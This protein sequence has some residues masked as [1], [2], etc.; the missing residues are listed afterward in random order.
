MRSEERRLLPLAMHHTAARILQ[1]KIVITIVVVRVKQLRGK[2]KTN[3]SR[4]E[5]VELSPHHRTNVKTE[6]GS[7]K[8]KPL[9]LESIVKHHIEAA[10]HGNDQLLQT[11]V[12]VRTPIG[13]TGNVIRVIDSLNVERDMMV[14]L[15]K[16]QISPGIRNFR[17]V[18]QAAG[19]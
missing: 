13:T 15:N 14:A 19:V 16:G 7:I 8:V 4:R 17:K 12:S 6:I 5:V 10:R 1:E 3:R 9:R 18:D 11:L 2:N